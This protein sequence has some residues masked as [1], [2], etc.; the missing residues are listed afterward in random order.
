M[1]TNQK[2]I[3]SA[4]I[5]IT[6]SY[7]DAARILT[8]QFAHM[9]LDEARA[10]IERLHTPVLSETELL[11]KFEVSHFEPLCV[12]VIRKADGRRGKLSF[13]DSPR[14]YFEFHMEEEE[15]DAGSAR[16]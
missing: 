13:I 3:P 16:V 12:H 6:A 4:E 10:A 7:Q 14:L 9:S 11:D 1:M 15:N 8:A 5:E 2:I